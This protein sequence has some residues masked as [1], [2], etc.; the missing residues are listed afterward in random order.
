MDKREMRKMQRARTR[1]EPKKNPQKRKKEK[2]VEKKCVVLRFSAVT[3]ELSHINCVK[4]RTGYL[5]L[6]ILTNSS[7]KFA[8][9]LY[10]MH[11]YIRFKY[12]FIQ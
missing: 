9:L 6:K 8:F 4:L 5:Y 2:C 1:T 11:E 10:A 3:K 12:T 7:S